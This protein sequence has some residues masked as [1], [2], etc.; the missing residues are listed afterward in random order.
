MADKLSRGGSTPALSVDLTRSR[1]G[2][3]LT[4]GDGRGDWR[5]RSRT[6][7]VSAGL[8]LCLHLGVD[9][10][11]VHKTTP[12]AR[13][14]CW[15]DPGEGKARDSIARNI[16]QQYEFWQ[17]RARYKTVVD[18]TTE[19][20]RKACQSMRR[21]AKEERV[22]LHY[23]G[24]GVPRATRGGELW[25]FNKQFTQY[26]PVAVSEI[27]QWIETPALIVL[28]CSAAGN[29]YNVC[30]RLADGGADVL[31]LAACGA[32]EVLPM[33]PEMPAD[34]F[35]SCLT[36]PMEIAIRWHIYRS[37]PLMPDISLER[38]MSISGRL[39][40]RRTPLGE[41][42]WILTAITDTIAWTIL[43]REIFKR[44]FRQDVLVASLFR[45]FLLAVRILKSLRCNALSWPQIPGSTVANHEM[46][47]AWDQALDFCL[48]QSQDSPTVYET[49][50]FFTSQLDS[51]ELWIEQR[52]LMGSMPCTA[53]HLAILLQV[54]LSQTHRSRALH[55]LG[56]FADMGDWAILDALHVG[57]FP[58]L[59]KLFQSPAPEIRYPLLYLW[60]RILL[61]DREVAV[62][63]RK[64]GGY[65][66]RTLIEPLE[67]SIDQYEIRAMA[68]TCLCLVGKEGGLYMGDAINGDVN[69]LKRLTE[70]LIG[71]ATGAALAL[72]EWAFHGLAMIISSTE[73]D[74]MEA[75]K[76]ELS[77]KAN[78]EASKT[79]TNVETPKTTK[80]LETPKTTKNLETPKTTTDAETLR[81]TTNTETPKTAS[82]ILNVIAL[83]LDRLI[84]VLDCE[85]CENRS[86][87]VH[88]LGCLVP[89]LEEDQE[90]EL[91]V[92]YS[93]LKCANDCHPRIRVEVVIALS[94]LVA[95]HSSKFILTA[96]D[97]W[98]D[99]Q[100]S[101]L[102]APGTGDVVRHPGVYTLVWKTCL[103][104]SIDP[105]PE[106]SSL[107]SRLVD[108]I[109]MGFLFPSKATDSD[110]CKVLFVNTP[111]S[112]STHPANPMS[113]L[114][115]GTRI[116]S[117]ALPLQSAL[118]INSATAFAEY[119]KRRRIL[120]QR[121]EDDVVQARIRKLQRLGSD[122]VC[123]WNSMDE[124]KFDHPAGV[125]A[126][127]ALV[128]SMVFHPLEDQLITADARGVV[129]V[130]D[131]TEERKIN[132]ISVNGKITGV[133]CVDW[134]PVKLLV[135][136]ADGIV[137]MYSD[138]ATGSS[139]IRASWN[140]GPL[141]ASE[142]GEQLLEWNQHQRRL[143][144]LTSD[145]LM[146]F[147]AAREQ[148]VQ[149]LQ[150]P[151]GRP[152]ALTS[153]RRESP[154]MTIG[155]SDGWIRRYDLR[156]PEKGHEGWIVGVKTVPWADLISASVDGDLLRWDLR[157]P[158]AQR[159][160]THRGLLSLDCHSEAALLA[161][162]GA[163]QSV[164]LYDGEGVSMGSIKYR[165][166]FMGQRI[167]PVT[168]L[169]FHERRMLLAI[170]SNDGTTLLYRMNGLG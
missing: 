86:A 167:A 75:S 97:L 130:W 35:T 41:L 40:D 159:I 20:L 163:D 6:R 26:I 72:S 23:N 60:H 59:L 25:V 162:A 80:N 54:L 110:Q 85:R 109:H 92:I 115:N 126:D 156:Q 69:V 91:E 15:T 105:Q 146:V 145:G 122:E 44:L 65:L 50:A 123:R 34:I 58:Y 100:G 107:A 108:E 9:P 132:S 51:F 129:A 77:K 168:A 160:D 12:T 158:T 31:V 125:M 142:E 36:T 102:V 133:A 8:V 112:T 140:F 70:T 17:P 47:Q 18:P 68:L 33:A 143:F 150:L 55:L 3:S 104:L 14:E 106:V 63:L 78:T 43:P 166:G 27:V 64:D 155:F 46:W 29:I 149:R 103:I 81:T 19:E 101:S 141:S 7:T 153:D 134:D 24:H 111:Y 89:L 71:F 136:T 164:R 128:S 157:N 53:P 165:E 37:G 16:Q 57:I 56:I 76:S 45:N 114:V 93:L 131:I 2:E 10:P 49:S 83:Q 84:S 5:I 95:R 30:R 73:S 96:Y 94:K 22:L 4:L 147:D 62:D 137:R 119:Q 169:S 38:A 74:Q 151:Q 113:G 127:T 117:S 32:D 135:G 61:F 98:N 118:L 161:V 21:G 154:L 13:L 148:I 144:S 52:S 42:N 39:G 66:V 138:F 82:L 121:R 124:R 99:H 67:E 79:T 152:T 90:P 170:G 139:E 88:L 28:D 116:L 1:S 48:S 11:D 87:A 120:I